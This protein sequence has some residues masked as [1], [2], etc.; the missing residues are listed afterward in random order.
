MKINKLISIFLFVL[1]VC[2]NV[3]CSEKDHHVVLEI[4]PQNQV[5]LKQHPRLLFPKEQEAEVRD[6]MKNDPGIKDLV[7]VLRNEA[8]RI[9]SLPK[10]EI[11]QVSLGISREEIKRIL[12]LSLAYRLFDDKRYAVKVEEELKHVCALNDWHPAHFLDVAEMTTAVAIGYDWCYDQLSDETHNMV[13]QAIRNNAFSHAWKEYEKGGPNSWAKRNTNWNV[14]CNTGLVNG[15]LAIADKYPE[16]AQ[17]IIQ[18]AILYTPANIEHFEPSGVYYEGPAYWGYTTTYLSQLLYNLQ[19]NFDT[20][21]GLAEM[22]GVSKTALY[23]TRSSSPTKGVFNFADAHGEHAIVAPVYFF[24][25]KKY[26]QPEVASYYREL[27]QE[28]MQKMRDGSHN[29][30]RFFWLTIPWYDATVYSGFA[31]KEKLQVYEGDTDMLVFNGNDEAQLYLMAKGGDP[32]MAHNQLDVGSF[33]LESQGE[34]WLVDLGS[35]NYSLPS[36]WDYKPNGVRWNYFLNNNLS[37]N[38]LNIDGNIQYSGGV[39]VL[40]GSNT[41]TDK[42]FGILELSICYPEQATKVNR[43]FKLINSS[44]ILLS[45]QIELK[46]SAKCNS[47]FFTRGEV[48]VNGNVVKL[49]DNDKVF[50]LMTSDQVEIKT[51]IAKTNSDKE[52]KLQG[53]TGIELSVTGNGKVTIP[54]Y[55]GSDI[56]VLKRNADFSLDEVELSQWK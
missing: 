2:C 17:R 4:E 8:T 54:V 43:G 44:T 39:G 20:T 33:I 9:L 32:D 38:T 23:Y 15:A 49:S 18:N 50:Y 31:G 46:A 25:S 29:F 53:I 34:R 7:D 10:Q 56:N 19:Y 11:T 14:V 40:S 37:H 6:L 45:D 26:N 21:Y 22:P 28:N 12:T 36:F 55:M 24:F 51:F 41:E 3:G 5:A 30:F 1:I 35:E 52:K 27:I 16:E 42:P 13:E 47:L 48:E